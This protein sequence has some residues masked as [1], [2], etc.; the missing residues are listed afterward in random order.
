MPGFAGASAAPQQPM[1]GGIYKYKPIFQ[2]PRYY[3]K[4]MEP[5]YEGY[6]NF[7]FAELN[8]EI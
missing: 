3:F 5:V 2:L 6:E 8:Y 4:N 1:I 7:S